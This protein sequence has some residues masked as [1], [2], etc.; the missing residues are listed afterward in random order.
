MK[1]ILS[2]LS[3]ATLVSA[4]TAVDLG[5]AGNYV[6]LAESGITNVPTSAVTGDVAISSGKAADI[7]AFGLVLDILGEF[8]ESPQVTGKVYASDYDKGSPTTASLLITAVGYMEAAYT[9]ITDLAEDSAKLDLGAGE[10]GGL[11]LTPGTYT[12]G[13]DISINSDVTFSGTGGGDI[14]IRTTK[15]FVQAA[16][17]KV[18]LSNGATAANIYWQVAG[19]VAV[20]AGAHLEGVILAKTHV[21]FK[22]GSSLNGRVLTQTACNLQ[23]ATITEA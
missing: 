8:S 14:I 19:N 13:T 4:A 21:T 15:N 7:T 3:A 1:F 9:A 22:T 2:L 11:T 23:M 18:I 17:K 5:T 12:F 20:G 6:I 16:G 10:I